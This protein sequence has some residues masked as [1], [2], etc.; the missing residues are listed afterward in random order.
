MNVSYE[1]RL[2]VFIHGTFGI[3]KSFTVKEWA[4]N[5]AKEMELTFSEN[6]ADINSEKH[7]MCLV[8]PLHQ[9][10][11]AEVKGIPVKSADGKSTEFLPTSLLP[12]TGNGILFFDELNLAPPMIQANAYQLIHDRR[13]GNYNLPDGYVS[14]GAGNTDSD[15]AHTFSMANPLKNRFGH[16]ELAVPTVERWVKDFAIPHGIDNR[17]IAFLSSREQYLFSYDAD[18]TNEQTAIA[19][20]RTWEMH[21]KAIEKMENDNPML[22]IFT[23]MFIGTG[24][25]REFMSHIKL[26]QSYDIASIMK[27]G[28][29]KVPKEIDSIYAFISGIVSYYLKNLEKDMSKRFYEVLSMLPKEYAFMG[30]FLVVKQDKEFFRKM[31]TVLPK[32]DMEKLQKQIIQIAT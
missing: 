8:I 16:V 6:V 32:T 1:N 29:F 3:G 7:F 11:S 18:A 24:I 15:M 23:G 25:A 31:K 21:S 20:P 30:M 14:Y 12:R 19:S 28:E 5:K 9:Y 4:K 27:G 13:L 22:E 26:I 2:P 10:D 17:T